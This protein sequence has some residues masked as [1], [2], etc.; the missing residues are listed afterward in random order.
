LKALFVGLG[1]VGQRHLRNLLEIS[2]GNLEFLAYRERG[3]DFVLTDKLSIDESVSL[4][5]KYD[6]KIFS[7][8][9]AALSKN[10][11]LVFIANPTSKHLSVA[12]ESVKS[13]CDF[14]IE[15]PLSHTYDGVDELIRTAEEKSVIAFVGYQNRYH[16]CIKMAKKLLT[17][18]RIGSIVAV[19]AEIGEY[20]PGWHKYED[21][22]N[23][24]ASREELGG[25]VV[26]SQIHEFDYLYRFFGEPQRVFCVG[27]KLSDLEIDVEDT[28]STLFEYHLD[29]KKIPVHVHQDYLQ[30]PSERRCRILGTEGKIEFDLLRGSISAY[31]GEG[32]A[33]LRESYCNFDR[34]EMFMEELRVFLSCVETRK[35]P[36][37]SLT[38]AAASLRMALAAKK[39]ME[40]GEI[41]EI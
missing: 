39:S 23:T 31:D 33:F 28:A 5:A 34:N 12:M 20:L 36:E 25:G 17:E 22:R 40:T 21:Y 35:R 29:G 19:N 18:K 11:D 41:V 10:P 7:D 38:D 1:S 16:P 3:F 14:F 4:Q 6:I 32:H 15:K 13:G 24:Y 2:P 26:L 8:L 9:R 27:G 30:T 37:I